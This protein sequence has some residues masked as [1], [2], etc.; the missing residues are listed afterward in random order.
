MD[1]DN[2]STLVGRVNAL[3]GPNATPQKRSHS[4]V[5]QRTTLYPRGIAGAP[6]YSGQRR[7]TAN[8]K[9]QKFAL[10][11]SFNVYV[12]LGSNQPC[13]NPQDWIKDPSFIGVS[14]VLSQPLDTNTFKPN[15]EANGAVPLTA[16][17]E[18]KIRSGE[19][20]CMR[21]GD[22]ARYLKANLKWRVS[23]VSTPI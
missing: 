10:N 16:A 14:G 1:E 20:P 21:E 12:F 6:N 3:Y 23:T 5:D 17:L 7:Y 11:G 4:S 22:V 15:I 2:K 18:A 13:D 9:A 8:I 19:L